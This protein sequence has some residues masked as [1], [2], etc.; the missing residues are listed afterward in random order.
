MKTTTYKYAIGTE[1]F[2]LH[3]IKESNLIKYEVKE[4]ILEEVVIK[5]SALEIEGKIYDKL[6]VEYQFK[7]RLVIEYT[8]E[9]LVFDDKEMAHSKCERLNKEAK[10]EYDRIDLILNPVVEE[11]EEK[12]RN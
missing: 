7:N 9:K 10:T 6:E 12:V 3:K 2:Y 1:I 11:T 4:D 8:E 5:V